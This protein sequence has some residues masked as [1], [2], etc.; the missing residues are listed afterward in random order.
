[1]VLD[2]EVTIKIIEMTKQQTYAIQ[3]TIYKEI[4]RQL[5]HTFGNLYYLDGNNNRIRINCFNGKAER[6]IGS[7]NKDK[8]L[9]L[10]YITVTEVGT[11]N[12]DSRRRYNPVLVNEKFWNVK[13]NKAQRVLSLANR[14]VDIS[15][16]IN[17]WCKFNEDMDAIRNTIFLL[18]NPDLDIRTIYSDYTKGFIEAENDVGEIQAEDTKD[19]VLKKSITIKVET[20]L[21]SPKFLFTN[22]GE[23][24]TLNSE[25]FIET[26]DYE[27]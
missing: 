18:F 9:I 4:I 23:I 7:A 19:R 25:V 12:S 10:P 1:M 2:P 22:T 3:K 24:E 13:K 15:Y 11:E 20:Y 5:I 17:I 8:T 26:G 14:P 27:L 6:L 21:P 16:E